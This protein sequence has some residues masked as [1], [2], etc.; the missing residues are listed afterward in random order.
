MRL[1]QRGAAF[2]PEAIPGSRDQAITVLRKAVEPGVNHTGTA[3]FCFSSLRSASELIN[4]A[5]APYPDDL[6]IAAKVGPRRDPSGERLAQATPAPAARAGRGEPVPAR[7]RLPESGE[8]APVR[9]GLDR[10]ALRYSGM[11]AR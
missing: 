10:R 11:I 4:T 5:L 2:A 3:G 1:P 9:A 7:P 8:P 6:V